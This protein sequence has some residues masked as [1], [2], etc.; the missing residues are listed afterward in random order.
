MPRHPKVAPAVAGI[1]GSVYS[2]LAHRM[3]T[4]QGEVY[5]LHVGDTWLEPAEGCRMQDLRV[6]EHPGMHRYA[7]PQGMPALLDRIV[8]RTRQRMGVPTERAN[9]L[10]TGGATGGLGAVAGAL[11]EPGDEVL[12]LAPAWPLMQ[13]IVRCFH[14]VPVQVPFIGVAESAA[15][16]VECVRQKST[17]RTVALYVS[18][19]NNPSGQV[20][21]PAWLE[22]LVGWATREN[23]W[24]VADEVYE[25][26]VYEGEH[27]YCRQLAPERTISVLSFSKAFGLAG[28]GCGY[29]VG[30]A[31]VL[32]ELVKVSTHS[33]YS[34]P[35]ASQLAACRALD[36]RGDAWIARVKP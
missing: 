12:I 28:N 13:G 23:L 20:I 35:T 7:A 14:G 22:A 19:P 24:I 9:L 10:I 2:A 17:A 26:Y 30:P 6:E 5:P 21:P 33:F 4:F 15:S 32:R 36:G 8:E 34:A 27:A 3:A 29:V 11:L 1:G 18:T 31:A 16:A 25:D